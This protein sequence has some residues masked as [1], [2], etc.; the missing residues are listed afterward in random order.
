[1]KPH[2]LS[3][4]DVHCGDDVDNNASVAGVMVWLLTSAVCLLST[5]RFAKQLAF[6]VLSFFQ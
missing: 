2:V 3:G 1:M 4:I 6:N 5:E